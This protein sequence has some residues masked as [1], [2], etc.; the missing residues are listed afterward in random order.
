MNDL[1]DADLLR[2]FAKDDSEAAFAVLVERH[3]S[4][5]HSVALR[6]TNDPQH[7]QDIA[8]AVFIILAR[9]AGSLDSKTV[10]SGWLYHTARL[11]AANFQR[12]ERRRVRREQEAFMQSAT[13]EDSPVDAWR[14]L[15][16]Q[17]ETAMAVL[18][19][20]DRDALV[21]RYFQNRSM[22][23]VGTA[24]G[25]T[26]NTAQQR[27]G[28]ALEKL[29]KLLGKRGIALT[30]GTIATALSANAVQAAPAGLAKAIT[31][32]AVT[33]GAAASVATAKLVKATLKIM[34][35]SNLVAA[36]SLAFLSISSAIGLSAVFAGMMSAMVKREDSGE[37]SSHDFLDRHNAFE[38]RKKHARQFAFF[39]ILAVICFVSYHSLAIWANV[40]PDA[41]RWRTIAR[42]IVIAAFLTAVIIIWR[43]I[44]G[45]RGWK[46]RLARRNEIIQKE[47]W[48]DDPNPA[49]PTD[50][51]YT[52]QTSFKKAGWVSVM[53]LLGLV[54]CVVS[55]ICMVRKVGGWIA[56]ATFLGGW[57]FGVMGSY[58]AFR[59]VRKGW[60][61][62]DARCIKQIVKVVGT[63][64]GNGASHGFSAIVIC[65]YEYAG[66]K[67]R[68]TPRITAV[69]I[70]SFPTP[71][72]VEWY[73]KKRIAPDGTCKLCFNPDNPLQTVLYG[74][75]FMDRFLLNN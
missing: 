8:Q 57:V 4:L 23:D 13:N 29:R 60:L 24:L 47:L 61:F 7:A 56:P 36:I 32:V 33:K 64:G 28:R 22:A 26:E 34:P 72:T 38:L 14:E 10:L 74:G 40:S 21:M 16:P 41:A 30:G 5:V 27:V 48:V 63:S 35:W 25:C 2:Q 20:A 46:A 19:P 51:D 59:N 17:L 39:G 6:Q 15:S 53:P 65:E 54:A 49:A 12:A 18:G 73:L 3:L 55:F 42:C 70:V 69:A 9:K 62:T 52:L 67:Y 68:V 58:L 44:G 11:T 71:Q 66:V 50:F 43:K 45:F 1:S 75:G 31:P 37:A